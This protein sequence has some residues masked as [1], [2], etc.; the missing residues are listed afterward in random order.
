[1][2]GIDSMSRMTWMRNLPKTYEY[3]TKHL[4]GIVLEGYNIVGMRYVMV[5]MLENLN[6]VRRMINRKT[7][8]PYRC[9]QI[10]G[11]GTPQ[12]LL[13]ILTGQTEVELPEARRGKPN[14][15]NID[16]HP[17]IFKDFQKIGYATQYAEEDTK[18][19]NN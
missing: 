14:A 12:A 9:F 2:F 3:F 10:T 15:K 6:P 11:D 5:K 16:G 4:E 8:L 13:P 7:V 1:M 19:G 17:W 18:T